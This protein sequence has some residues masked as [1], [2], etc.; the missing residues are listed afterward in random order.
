MNR[1]NWVQSTRK[2]TK[3]DS[4]LREEALSGLA[5]AQE[6]DHALVEDDEAGADE[7]AHKANTIYVW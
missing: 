4:L 7:A 5:L 6:H 1:S 3:A 2:V